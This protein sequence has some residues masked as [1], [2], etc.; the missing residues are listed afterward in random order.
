MHQ[1]DLPKLI[2][3]TNH[4][5]EKNQ[6]TSVAGHH[7]STQTSALFLSDE[8]LITMLSLPPKSV[9]QMKTKS[10]FQDFFRG[11]PEERMRRLLYRAY[12]NLNDL[13]REVKVKK[14]MELLA[15]VLANV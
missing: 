9:P 11:I 2:S 13:E 5:Q 3:P 7:L 8:T 6:E 12:G 4:N 1:S 15:G 10:S 14:R